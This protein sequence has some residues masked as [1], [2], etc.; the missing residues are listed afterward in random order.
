MT[1]IALLYFTLD[2]QN[3][4]FLLLPSTA[5]NKYVSYI[6]Y[7]IVIAKKHVYS[8]DILFLD[9]LNLDLILKNIS[10]IEWSRKILSYA[11]S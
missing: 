10:F 1:S 3:E 9:R 7:Q 6:T 8:Y 4:Q 5:Y 2:H 11:L